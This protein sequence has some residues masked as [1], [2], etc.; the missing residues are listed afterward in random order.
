MFIGLAQALIVSLGD[1]L[2]VDIQCHHPVL[3]VLQACMNGI[4]FTMINYA[5]TFA[6]ENIGL[7][8]G[9]IILVLQVAGSGGTYPVEVLPRI[10]K[11]LYPVMPFRYSM[12]AMRECIGGTY[13]HT[14]AKCMGVLCLFFIGS[15]LLGLILHRPAS[16]LNRLIQEGKDKSEIML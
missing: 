10:F 16:W 6:L 3:F 14:Y 15:V 13:D 12:N 5:L 7:G 1:L 9:V 4:V 11:I 2:Y 8:I